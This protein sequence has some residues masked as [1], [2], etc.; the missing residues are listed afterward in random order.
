MTKTLL[1]F[2]SYLEK[3]N[4]A[5]TKEELFNIYSATVLQHGLDKVLLCL[6]TDHRDIGEDAGMKFMHNYP[7]DWMSYYFEKE[8]N[9]IDPVI[10]YG[11][12][13]ADSFKWDEVTRKMNLSRAQKAC[14]NLGVEAGLYNGICTPLRGPSNAIGGLSLAASEKR[15][16]F[17]GKIDLITA[18]SNHFY[19]A[20][21]RLGEKALQGAHQTVCNFALTAK[22]RDVLSWAAKGKSYG[23]IATILETSDHTIDFHIRN[24]FKKLEVNHMVL[25]VV[26]AMTYGLIHP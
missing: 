14:M 3:A 24:I 21:R 9:T 15:D 8:L 11:F 17:D 18:Y 7:Q 19:L 26:K 4:R 20:Y 12:T 23:D 1:N 13:V 10:I 16:S 6:A 22:E 25:A 2:E 5:K